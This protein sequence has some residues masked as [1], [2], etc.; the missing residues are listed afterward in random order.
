MTGEVPNQ[1]AL[2]LLLSKPDPCMLPASSGGCLST[3]SP[4]QTPGHCMEQPPYLRAAM[5]HVE[6]QVHSVRGGSCTQAW[7]SPLHIPGVLPVT[8]GGHNPLRSSAGSLGEESCE[9]KAPS[10]Y[11][12][13]PPSYPLLQ[14]GPGLRGSHQ[15]H[16]QLP[17]LFK[18]SHGDME[19]GRHCV[20]PSYCNNLF[21]NL[22]PLRWLG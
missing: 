11:N 13:P 9:G 2:P 15:H 3:S 8:E 20:N 10:A 19:E 17:A 14:H 4:E 16:Q 1:K 21:C 18:E 5:E 12:L 6:G 7:S 22:Y